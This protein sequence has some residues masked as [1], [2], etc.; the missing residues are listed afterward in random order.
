MMKTNAVQFL[1][2]KS[3]T[4]SIGHEWRMSES[5]LHVQYNKVPSL[6]STCTRYKRERTDLQI[7]L[8][9]KTYHFVKSFM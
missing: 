5:Y 9:S 4:Q 2:K 3:R 8:V 7:T 6:T 1:L